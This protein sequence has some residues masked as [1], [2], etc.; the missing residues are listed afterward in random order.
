MGNLPSLRFINLFIYF[1]R[2]SNN[3]GVSEVASIPRFLKFIWL[4][5]K[6]ILFNWGL[7]L[8]LKSSS[9][10]LTSPAIG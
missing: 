1:N 8:L 6:S 2:S 9:P 4:E 7:R 5:C 3:L 10:Y